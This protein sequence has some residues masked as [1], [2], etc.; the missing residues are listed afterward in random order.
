MKKNIAV[1]MGGRSLEREF[2]IK[3]GQRISNA[4]R[5]LGHN[6]IKL[7]INESIVDNLNSEKIDLAYIALHGKDG[8]DGT[9]QEILEV[10]NIPYTGPGVY[11]NVLSFDKII[12]KQ[13]FMSLGIPTPPFYFLNTSSFREL[14][15]SKLLPFIIKKIGLPMVVKPSAQGSALGIRI[16]NEKESIPEAIIS[17]LSYS[18]KVILEKFIDGVE[19]A[20]S[21]IG[22][23]KPRILPAVEIVTKKKFFDFESRSK[24]GETDYF[25]PARISASSD[26]KMKEVAMVVHNALKC[27][28]LSRVDIIMDIKEEIPYV[29][30]L[31]TSPGMT[32]TSLLP[33][34][35]EAAGLSFEE[36][37]DEIIKMSLKD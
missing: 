9:I 17:A 2:S 36:L 34:S 10:L 5:K 23:E 19:L 33:M 7:D 24:T 15:S 6:V 31:N 26:K 11:P 3:S 18:K 8:E 35:A 28:K 12:S 25:V 20:V 21:I 1:L 37:V 22:K 30:E 27:T 16:V 29:L 32:D 13:I 4:L 14:G